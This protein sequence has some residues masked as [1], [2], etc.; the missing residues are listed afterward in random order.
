M[1]GQPKDLPFL[2]M[3]F[4]GNVPYG[5][6]SNGMNERLCGECCSQRR[7][8]E[9]LTFVQTLYLMMSTVHNRETNTETLT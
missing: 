4:Q 2:E 8:T 6:N 3:N 1:I 7:H 5:L 9:T